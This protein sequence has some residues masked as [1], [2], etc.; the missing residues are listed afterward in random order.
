MARAYATRTIMTAGVLSLLDAVTERV[1][2]VRATATVITAQIVFP[3]AAT[4][5]GREVKVQRR[6]KM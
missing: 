6:T 2:S 5:V 4:T 3:V 1:G